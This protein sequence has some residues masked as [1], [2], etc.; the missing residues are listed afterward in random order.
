MI[1]V[2][3]VAA[4]AAL[5]TG[6]SATAKV[7]ALDLGGDPNAYIVL[8]KDNKPAVQGPRVAFLANIRCTSGQG[9]GI[10]VV[11]KQGGATGQGAGTTKDD[12]N[13]GGQRALVLMQKLSASPQFQFQGPLAVEGF[14]VTDLKT[15]VIN[16]IRTDTATLSPFA[17]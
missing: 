4:V 13:G 11:G 8:S 16:D 12:C 14:A 6:G 9:A 7:S 15:G 10:V 3:G 2:A 1:L 17:P 5:A